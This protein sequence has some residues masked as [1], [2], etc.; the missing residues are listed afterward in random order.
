MVVQI[1]LPFKNQSLNSRHSTAVGRL[2]SAGYELYDFGTE[3]PI[4][5]ELQ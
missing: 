5:I 2:Q 3:Y 4:V 1:S